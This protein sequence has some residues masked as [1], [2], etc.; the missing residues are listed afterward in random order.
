MPLIPV[1][2]LDGFGRIKDGYFF[3]T[4]TGELKRIKKDGSYTVLSGSVRN[5]I[6]RYNL[7]IKREYAKLHLAKS[8][9]VKY[10]DLAKKAS[11]A[12]KRL[13]SF[14]TPNKLVE[15]AKAQA[16]GQKKGWVIGAV[17]DGKIQLSAS[18][19]VHDTEESV[20]A[21]IERL[22]L[23]NKSTTFVK[24]KVENFVTCGGVQ[25]S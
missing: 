9:S 22:A 4:E 1:N 20:N 5:G 13:S 18:P 7:Q 8:C 10:N 15:A 19:K 17:R 2:S 14:G 23:D 11:E 25:W 3:N 21:E 6:H 24:L 12:A 16:Q